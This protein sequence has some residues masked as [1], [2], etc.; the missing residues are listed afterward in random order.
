VK[1]KGAKSGTNRRDLG[2]SDDDIALLDP[3]KKDALEQATSKSRNW[4]DVN[5]LTLIRAV[6]D[7]KGGPKDVAKTLGDIKR[8]KTQRIRYAKQ[9]YFPG[10]R[11]DEKQCTNIWDDAVKRS[12][13]V[14]NLEEH[15]GGG[16]GEVVLAD[17]VDSEEEDGDK[18]EEAGKDDGDIG[19]GNEEVGVED[20]RETGQEKEGEI[21]EPR[22]DGGE[23]GETNEADRTA[24]LEMIGAETSKST[25]KKDQQEAK[26]KTQGKNYMGYSYRQL[27]M[28]SHTEMHSILEPLYVFSLTFMPCIS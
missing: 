19:V 6:I 16:D 18:A 8:E 15:T 26:P 11:P 10:E 13:A 24:K 2:G 17:A 9:K 22:E 21:E 28:W 3:K 20:I 27:E 12:T 4:S 23:I 25:S 14:I 5:K 7:Y 1:G